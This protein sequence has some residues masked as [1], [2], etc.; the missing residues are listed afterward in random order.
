M[1]LHQFSLVLHFYILG[2]GGGGG[3][4]GWWLGRV[5]PDYF[6]FE[7]GRILTFSVRG[8]GGLVKGVGN[9]SPLTL[10]TPVDQSQIFGHS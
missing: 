2:G 5:E 8:V 1:H 6:Y 7:Q 4:G 9:F 10:L 3:G